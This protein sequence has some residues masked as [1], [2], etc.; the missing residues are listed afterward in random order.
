MSELKK[1]DFAKVYNPYDFVRYEGAIGY[2]Y[3]VNINTC[4]E[5]FEHQV[6]YACK[7]VYVNPSMPTPH[8]AWFDH[9][10][11]E[12]TGTNLFKEIAKNSCNSHGGGRYDVDALFER[13]F[14]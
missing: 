10:E 1:E 13:G 8:N 4:Q 7:W 2:I 14:K 5:A 6:S 12:P 9:T 3:E 11:L